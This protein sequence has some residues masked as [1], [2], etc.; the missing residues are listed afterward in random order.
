MHAGGRPPL[1]QRCVRSASVALLFGMAV[2]GNSA[3]SAES[4]DYTVSIAGVKKSGL[5]KSIIDATQ[6]LDKSKRSVPTIRALRRRVEAS[7]PRVTALLRA[8]A[9]Y[10]A[11]QEFSI[12]RKSDKD[13]KV[14]I[15]I[16]L[17]PVYRI[18]RY[19]IRPAASRNP[20]QPIDIP[21][22][23]LGLMPGDPAKSEI[24]KAADG[25][26]LA[27]LG[28][29][30]YPLARIE[31]R[32]IVVDHKAR[33]LSVEITVSTG[34]HA[35][36]GKIQTEGL[37]TV[38]PGL[39]TRQ[40]TWVRGAP[41]DSTQF[42]NLRNNLRQTGLF[43]SVLVSHA[44]DV[45][46]KG[47][48]EITVSV[49]ERKHRSIGAGGSFSTTEG[50]LGKLFWEHRNL[51]GHG[52]RLRLRGEVGEIRQG[53]FGD[54]RL[55]DFG[56]RDQDLVFDARATK[57]QPDG[58]TSVE[59]AATARLERR[60]SQIYA[61]SAGVGFDRS[62]VEENATDRDFT[63]L[64]FPLSLRRD[65]SDDLLD[66]G[67]GGRD[68]LNFTP[69]IGIVGTDTSFYAAR[70]FDTVYFPLMAE[71]KLILAGW[72]RIGTIF[73]DSTLDIPANKRLYSGG[74]GSIRGYA[75]NS[76]GPL[77]VQNDPIGGRSSTEFGIELR[78]RAVGPFGIVAFAEA[79]GIYD[80][81]IPEWGKKLQWG[82]GL[83]VRY[84]TKIGPLRLD[85]AVPLNRRNSVDDSFQVL[86]SLGQA[87]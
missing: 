43:S 16:D 79:G 59:T 8:R 62:N 5:K 56:V 24:I 10:A 9:Y 58:F 1:R 80:D 76:I 4:I 63:F 60:F 49:K 85:V 14:T 54:L 46:S 42:E 32:R 74:A 31:N 19:D 50:P 51:W 25:H 6:L 23:T 53:A 87:F 64:T 20:R 52:E 69:N 44:P 28:R 77:D 15:K 3:W 67:K 82:A 11:K 22:H 33:T 55:S 45:D 75:L 47:E 84:L 18:G 37:A 41:F 70:L 27:A 39:I 7:Q 61:G 66:P 2:V 36:F 12:D 38:A 65:T 86:V 26:L 48:L 71:K 78:W 29:Q 21:F 40:I 81:P 83:G 57:E 72:A 35:R 13:A 17:G 30:A 73:G 34:P 68:T